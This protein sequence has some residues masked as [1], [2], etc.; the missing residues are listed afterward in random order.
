VLLLG[1]VEEVVLVDGRSRPLALKLEDHDT[2]VVTGGE[3]VDLGMRSNNPEPVRRI[4][5]WCGWNR[6]PEAFWK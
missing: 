1:D 2:V 4:K 5:S 6:Q 3:Q